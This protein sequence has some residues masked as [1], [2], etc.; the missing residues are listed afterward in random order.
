MR[1]GGS[2]SPGS[3]PGRGRHSGGRAPG[4]FSAGIAAAAGIPVFLYVVVNEIKFDTPFSLPLNRQVFSYESAHRQAVLAANG[5]SLFGLKFLPTN[6]LQFARPDAFT[7]TRTFPWIFFPGKAPVLGH[8][9]YDT[10]DWTSS[11]PASMPVLF[12]LA[13]VGAVVVYRPARTRGKAPEAP[14][15]APGITAL[16]LPLAGAA[17]GTIGILTIAFIAERYLADAMPLL[18]LAGLAGWHVMA[19]RWARTP[20]GVRR[21]G[22]PPFWPCS[23]CS[24]S[25]RPYP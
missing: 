19:D 12:L 23:R 4:R 2:R 6:L 21:I 10:R 20:G 15:P 18:L 13:V 5:G 7:V 25:G 24:S 3:S 11:V 14:P 16:R 17:V 1:P 8:L 22:W 9:L